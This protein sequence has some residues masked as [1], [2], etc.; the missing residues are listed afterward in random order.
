MDVYHKV[1]AKL[2]EV[3]GGKESQVV[4][5]KD[6]V[7]KTGF[8]GNYGDIFAQLSREGWIAESKKANF[9]S[10]THWGI[11]EAKKSEVAE[12]SDG[13]SLSQSNPKAAACAGKAREL[14]SLLENFPAQP[15]AENRKNLE[16]EFKEFEKA[17]REAVL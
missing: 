14:A 7:K 12:V 10:I 13:E 2:Y 6:L 4:D 9:V 5:F 15:S 11:S 16:A 8:H 1:L 3:T 17:F